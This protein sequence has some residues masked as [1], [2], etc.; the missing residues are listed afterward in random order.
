M[1]T[2]HQLHD[3]RREAVGGYAGPLG[4]S[5]P[6]GTYANGV[7]LRRQVSADHAATAASAIP[8][9]TAAHF[10]RSFGLLGGGNID[11]PCFGVNTG[12]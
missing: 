5:A 10:H 9:A 3:I 1:S 4:P 2:I 7:L 6:I 8:A 12:E 11:G